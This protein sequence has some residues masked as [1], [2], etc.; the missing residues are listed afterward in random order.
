MTPR[1][2]HAVAVFKGAIHLLAGKVPV[3][4]AHGPFNTMSDVWRTMD[5]GARA[6]RVRARGPPPPSVCV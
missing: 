1:K 3:P 4:G 6:A 5:G 2:S